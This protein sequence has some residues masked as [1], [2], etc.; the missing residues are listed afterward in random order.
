[1]ED[2]TNYFV[3]TMNQ[4][5]EFSTFPHF[6][7]VAATWGYVPKDKE[8]VRALDIFSWKFD[9][10]LVGAT[11]SAWRDHNPEIAN[12]VVFNGKYNPTNRDVSC[13]VFTTVVAQEERL[14]QK[15]D[16]LEDFLCKKANVWDY[17]KKPERK[18]S[19]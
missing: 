19:I 9:R 13:G 15:S 8:P 1:M 10:K 18:K 2:A 3:Q 6:F 5:P 12:F 7:S 11:G 17:I 16:S 14:R 4:H